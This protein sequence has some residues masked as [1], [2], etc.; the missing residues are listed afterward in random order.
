[1]PKSSAKS[2]TAE[3]TP[4]PFLSPTGPKSKLSNGR[5]VINLASYNFYALSTNPHLQERAIQILRTYGVGPCSPPGFYGT[6][7]VHI[8]TEADI[9]SH[10]GTQSC[11]VYAQAFSTISSVIPA[12]SKRGDIIVADKAVNYAIRKGIQ[13]S[14]SNVRWYE[15]NDLED[16]ERVLR[17][18]V[19]E[20]EGRAL[21]RRFIVTEGL[22]ENVGDMLDLPRV[23]S[24][25]PLHISCPA[26]LVACFRI[27]W[28]HRLT[29]DKPRQ[30]DLKQKYKFRLILDESL[31]FGVLGRTA[32]GLTEHSNVDPVHIDMIVGSLAGPLCAGG[33]FCAGADEIV[34]HQRISALAYTFSAALPAMLATTASEV[35]AM[36]A[37]GREG[38]ELLSAVRENVR[39]M[40]AQLDPRSEWVRCTSSVEN[41]VMLLVLKDEVVISRKWSYRDQE[42][43]LQD[44]VDEALA[45][46][47]MITRLKSMPRGIGVSA[48]E[49][50][51]ECQPALKVCVTG[52][53]SRKEVEKAGVVVRHAITKV[54]KGRK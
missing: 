38:Q 40:W 35:L 3:L 10:L 2:T 12:F 31:S 7:D 30:I 16:L 28:S 42:L 6:Q 26:F 25:F 9:A 54:V 14:R 18:V 22:F 29:E 45:N 49:V 5:T 52:G 24:L 27:K 50:G 51:W 20:Q 44:V 48:K 8:K 15:H 1:M 39:A 21:T 17:S 43:V 13:I 41:P 36:L 23:V 33:G 53:L 11:I 32:R 34:E 19:K 46:G 4:L 47:V 37:G